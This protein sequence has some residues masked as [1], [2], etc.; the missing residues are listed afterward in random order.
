MVRK[1]E[2]VDLR[3][4][5]VFAAVVE[6]GGWGPAQVEMNINQ[7][8]LSTHMAEL[9]SR[10]GVKLCDRGR[11]GFRLTN[12]GKM[13]YE[14]AKKLFLHLDEF[15]STVRSNAGK[16]VGELEVATIDHII[17]NEHYHFP[18]AL[19]KVK[20]RD[21]SV[22]INIHVKSPTEVRD[23]VAEGLYHLGIGTRLK[24]SPNVEFLTLFGQ[25][26]QLYCGVDHPLYEKSD[27]DLTIKELRNWEMVTPK[28]AQAEAVPKIMRKSPS[29]T[30]TGFNIEAIAMLVLSGEFIAYLPENYAQFWCEKGR[31]RAIMPDTLDAWVEIAL[32]LKKN[33]SYKPVVE[34]FVED[35]LEVHKETCTV[36]A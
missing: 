14:A 17:N 28:F 13:V 5:R 23:G 15:N 27:A 20:R 4:L 35:L 26:H 29:M 12:D 33:R 19:K 25:R 6:H 24:Q 16:L 7:S 8:T 9:E 21:G 34:A 1:I 11:S 36:P 10:F 31:M 22:K 32:V 18:E 2:Q 30:A 3:L